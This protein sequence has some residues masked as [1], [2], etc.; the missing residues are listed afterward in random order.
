MKKL[1][2]SFIGIFIA[3]ATFAQ[4]ENDNHMQPAFDG[5]H[6]NIFVEGLGAGLLG[7]INYDM[8]LQRGRIDGIG[9]RAGIGGFAGKVT[10]Y[11]ENPTRGWYQDYGSHIL[12]GDEKS[13]NGYVVTFPLEANYLI[14]KRRSY[15]IAGIG[16]IPLFVSVPSRNIG[17]FGIGAGYLSLGYRFQ[18]LRNGF[19]FQINWNP[20]ISDGNISP[21]WLGI[22]VGYGFK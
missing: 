6:K 18:P 7:S 12:F 21:N 9:F 16:A 5:Y 8:R 20:I 3:V 11:D 1:L 14:G 10:V 19:M 13:E 4:S 22:S 15:F 2:L 17:K